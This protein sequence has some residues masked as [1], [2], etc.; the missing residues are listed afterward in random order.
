MFFRTCWMMLR[1]V[2]IK[3]KLHLHLLMD[4][5]EKKYAGLSKAKNLNHRSTGRLQRK[6]NL[7][8]EKYYFR[9]PYNAGSIYYYNYK[10]WLFQGRATVYWICLYCNYPERLKMRPFSSVLLG[11]LVGDVL[12]L[13]GFLSYCGPFNQSFRDMLLKDIWEAELRSHK[14]PFTE[15]LNL[16]S[17]LVDP[18]TVRTT[19]TCQK[20]RKRNNSL[21]QW[22][23]LFMWLNIFTLLFI[24]LR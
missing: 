17:A 13:T 20:E 22:L 2:G 19:Q 14:I 9:D 5:V 24:C 1:C 12:Q 7:G 16:I 21:L 18:P 8:I 11:R 23:I 4:L 6:E 15:N 10:V 3:C